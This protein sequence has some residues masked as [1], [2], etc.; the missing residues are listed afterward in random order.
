MRG[1]TTLATPTFGCEREAAYLSTA[2]P[3]PVRMLNREV[4][5]TLG[6]PNRPNFMPEHLAPQGPALYDAARPSGTAARRR[7]RPA[8]EV[9]RAAGGRR[10]VGRPPRSAP[11]RACDL[12]RK[13]ES[14]AARTHFEGIGY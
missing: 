5:P 12:P 6:N 14:G 2:M 4:L 13:A 1:S 8:A 3:A 9:E 11:P 7:R 10:G